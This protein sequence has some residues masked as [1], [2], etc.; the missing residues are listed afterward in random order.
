M[1]TYKTPFTNV[2]IKAKK[3]K[4]ILSTE[5]LSQ[6]LLGY[7]SNAFR[8]FNPYY[9]DLE[10]YTCSTP[11]KSSQAFKT[12]CLFILFGLSTK[13]QFLIKKEEL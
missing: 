3:I 7:D 8:Q 13:T 12:K 5:C 10:T 1:F 11:N 9:R 6:M 2:R 4:R